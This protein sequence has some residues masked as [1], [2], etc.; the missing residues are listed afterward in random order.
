MLSTT[1][2]LASLLVTKAQFRENLVQTKKK[3][4]KKNA[5]YFL[6]GG[7]EVLL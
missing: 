1:G 2:F 6:G 4:K 3:L 7:V 5:A